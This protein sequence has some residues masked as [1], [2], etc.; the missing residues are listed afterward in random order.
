MP[1]KS[2]YPRLDIPRTDILTYLFPPNTTPSD[3]PLWLDSSNPRHSLSPRQLLL[4]VKRLAVGLDKIGVK[5]GEVVMIHTPNHIFVPVAYLGIVGSGRVFSGANPVYTASEMV[6]QI[7]TT[8]ATVILS[9]P[10]LAKTAVA[11]AQKAGLPEGHVFLF[12]D[13]ENA[14]MDGVKDWRSMLGTAEEGERYSWHRMSEE[15]ALQT[16]ATVNFSSGTTGL[17]KGVSISHANLIANIE[18]TIVMRYDRRP[19]GAHN[20][21]PER[22]IGFLPLYHA[23]GQCYTIL[24]NVKLQV[25]VYVMKA[26]VY[27]DFLRVI[28]TYKITDLQVAPPILVMLD[29]RPETV[30]YDLSSVKHILCGAAPLSK[31]LQNSVSRRFNVVVC[32]GWGMTEVTCSGHHVPGG[33]DDDSGSVGLLNPN[34]ECM[35]LD[36]D[37]KE[38]APGQPGEMYV[39]G[40]QVCLGY[41]RNEQATKEALSPDGWLKTGDVAVVKNDWFW[42]V[43]RKKELIKVNALQVA[44]AELEAV[45]LEHD[46]VADAAVCGITLHGEEWPRAYIH[47]K[48]TAKGSLT[49]E[50]IHAW[51]KEKVA[52]HKQLVG[53]IMFVDEVP[54]LASGKI[55]RKIIREWAKR[56]AVALEGKVKARL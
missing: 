8:G 27:E 25:P 43:D 14:P 55:M 35:L 41:W 19:Y 56:D 36:D 54:K 10:T 50:R 5:S 44:P 17:P 24:M 31:E 3:T 48:D 6:H 51:M 1:F 53:G 26:F 39:R 12:S 33:I 28:Q 15:E 7:K 13:E 22:W 47:L 40:P 21:P 20:K 16:V 4:W 42:I 38:V 18:Q 2:P 46:E 9:H 34:T 52:K 32:Q 37:G 29:K 30:K 49:E 11:A 45:L 23:Y